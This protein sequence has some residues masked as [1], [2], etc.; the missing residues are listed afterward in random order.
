MTRTAQELESDFGV[1]VTTLALD[2]SSLSSVR[3]A[4]A[5]CR[6][7][8][9][10]GKVDSLS[11]LVCNAGARQRSYSSSADGFELTFAANYLG[12]FLLVELL[13]DRLADHGRVVF[14]VSGTHDP[15]TIDGRMV[16]RAVE[17]DAVALAGV[18]K[19][20]AK[21]GKKQPSLGQLYATSK[22]CMVMNAY[23][24]DRRL[25]HSGS[26]LCSIAFDPGSTSGTGFL[27]D[28]PRPVRWLSDS[29]LMDPLM[30]RLG[31]TMGSVE[32]SGTSL[33][34]LAADP[35]F[36]HASGKYFQSN[37]GKL[38]EAH[39]SKTSYDK[40]RALKLWNDSKTLVHLQQDEEPPQL[41]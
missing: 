13:T 23:E 8:L 29:G 5:E 34:D 41:R 7:L 33:A 40:D 3:S 11:A 37:Q 18:G 30:R 4:A 19:G 1:T 22:L 2:T 25:R 17:P 21:D 36:A 14:T 6:D 10:S 38:I 32:F 39:S 12:H 20:P 31:V 9:A 24:L 16:G 27:D 28:W 26:D 35:A 15:D